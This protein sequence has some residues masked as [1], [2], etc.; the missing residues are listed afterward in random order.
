M[1]ELS[2]LQVQQLI[3]KGLPIR[4]A[5]IQD[6]DLH[7]V[8]I[9]NDKQVKSNV[10]FELCNI[11]NLGL[12]CMDFFEEV[13]IRNCTINS[14]GFHGSYFFKGVTIIECVFNDVFYF[15]CGGHN[16]SPH[17]VRLIDN[18]FHGYVDFF[19]AWFMGPVEIRNCKF[20]AG[21][22]LLCDMLAFEIK[23]IIEHNEGNLKI[24]SRT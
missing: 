17:A 21:S 13:I 14:V 12:N 3:A 24:D 9:F 11:D 22:N 5:Q 8:S 10:I 16:E 23:P 6:I 2:K 4:D 1:K 7:N 20:K 18:I 19:D 15:D